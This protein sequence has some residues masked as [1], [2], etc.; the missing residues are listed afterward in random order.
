MG[1]G[2]I[3]SSL[4]RSCGLLAVRAALTDRS[5]LMISFRI[6]S[7]LRRSGEREFLSDDL[8]LAGLKTGGEGDLQVV[9]LLLM[10]SSSD[11]KS[12]E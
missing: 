5:H 10:L 1:M 6:P 12:G 11:S 9:A 7:A 8:A 3:T 2:V 4:L